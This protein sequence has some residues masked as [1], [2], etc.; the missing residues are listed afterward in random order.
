MPER[1]SRTARAASDGEED[2]P[3]NID[4][5]PRGRPADSTGTHGLFVNGNGR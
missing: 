1:T 2:G 5:E 3:D 4:V